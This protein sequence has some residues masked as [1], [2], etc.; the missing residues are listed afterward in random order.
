MKLKSILLLSTLIL[1]TASTAVTAVASTSLTS[2][3]P[4]TTV[5]ESPTMPENLETSSSSTGTSLSDNTEQDNHPMGYY[6]DFQTNENPMATPTEQKTRAN[7]PDNLS[8]S[9]KSLPRKDAIDIAS[10]QS[11]MTQSDFN[12]LKAQGVKTVIVKLTEGTYYKNPYAGSHIQMARKAGL[13]IATYHF[14]I[15]GSTS[16]QS[17]ANNAAIAEAN[18]YIAEAKRLGLASN[19]VM[20]NDAEYSGTA[21]SVWNQASQN[22]TNRIKA[23]GYANVRQY[24]SKSWADNKIINPA[25][26][27]AKN[28]WVAQYLYGKPSANNLQNTQYGAWQYT[29]QMYFT[30]FSNQ[31]PVDTSIDY[32]NIFSATPTITYPPAPAPTPPPTQGPNVAYQA[33]AQYYGWL[34][35]NYDGQNAGTTGLSL[36]MEALKISLMNLPVGMTGGVQYNTH[37]QSLGWQGWKNS[38]EIAGTQGQSL[39]IEALQ[40]KLTGSIAEEY[41]IYYRVHDQIA[42]WL[43]WAKNGESAGSTGLAWRV[44]A[45]NIKLVKKG[46][47][48]PGNTSLPY[49]YKP[50]LTYQSH[51]QSLGWQDIISGGNVTGTTG[52]A[53]RLEA[54]TPTLSNISKGLSGNLNYQAHVQNIGWQSP[55][56]TGT[57]GTTGK[58]LRM[59]AVKFSLTGNLAKYF[60]IR[61]RSHI[62][63]SG[64]E[65]WTKN[66]NQ[67]G[68]TGKELRM[69]AF[70]IDIVVKN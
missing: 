16:N 64:W 18:Y 51:I 70:Q 56:N 38:N 65:E 28:M 24:T 35:T 54:L 27:G 49:L 61:Y 42:G 11:W 14:S 31:K 32:N 46:Q 15:F 55:L 66:G 50:T 63:S 57:I 1:T 60:D 22:F 37:V 39:R 5:S 29:S 43:D 53:L 36:R 19:T 59:E 34:P 6:T 7:A 10:Y 52:K 25:T 13:N 33:H 20:I 26:F 30:G 3:L 45:I 17:T 67:S 8:S 9:D 69:E 23:Q 12:Q 68:T 58:G 40:L 62:Q 48:A 47:S 21:A 41:D 44:E 4:D 2:S